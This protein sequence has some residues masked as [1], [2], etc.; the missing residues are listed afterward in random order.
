MEG[1]LML[2]RKTGKPIAF[3]C[4]PELRQQTEAIA[5]SLGE[6][7]SDYVRKAVEK[8]NAQYKPKTFTQEIDELDQVG[9]QRIVNMMVCDLCGKE[10]HPLDAH[11]GYI[12]NK[13][14]CTHID[15]WNKHFEKEIAAEKKQKPKGD[16]ITD[17]TEA[18]INGGEM[19]PQ[20]GTVKKG[21][22]YFRPCPKVGK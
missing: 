10:L 13:L 22:D 2:P 20:K 21:K 3:K 14:S 9:N 17:D 8:R 11:T 15:C 16:G 4:T 5:D 19:K 18:I 7:L 12:D 1:L 6:S